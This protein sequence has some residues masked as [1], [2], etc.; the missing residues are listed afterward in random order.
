M[1]QCASVCVCVFKM[2][3]SVRNS[4][5]LIGLSGRVMCVCTCMMMCVRVQE[6]VCV[7]A[8]IH[9]IPAGFPMQSPQIDTADDGC[10]AVICFI[11]LGVSL[12]SSTTVQPSTQL[13]EKRE[14]P[15]CAPVKH[16]HTLGRQLQLFGLAAEKSV[17]QSGQLEYVEE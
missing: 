11:R 10:A 2:S 16:F 4:G 5:V 8:C 6:F 14:S 12:S 1:Y 17:S 15:I 3:S 13:S 9:L 7:Y